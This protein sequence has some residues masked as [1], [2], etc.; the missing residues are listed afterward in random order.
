[1]SEKDSSAKEKHDLEALEDALRR[2]RRP[3]LPDGL[4]ARLVAAI[5]ETRTVS[6]HR[7]IAPL[8]RWGAIAAAAF[9]ALVLGGAL[10]L[11]SLPADTRVKRA[12]LLNDTSAD[13]ILNASINLKI[14]ETNT[15]DILAPM[16]NWQ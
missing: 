7:H 15:C 9:V 6:T 11:R 5:P 12:G 3:P 2:V 4:E 1:M 14:K 13:H 10:I 16:P 8:A